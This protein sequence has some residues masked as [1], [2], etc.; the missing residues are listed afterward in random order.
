MR[1]CTV[2]LC[3]VSPVSLMPIHQATRVSAGGCGMTFE[4]YVAHC[5]TSSTRSMVKSWWRGSLAAAGNS[6]SED[7]RTGEHPQVLVDVS[8]GKREVPELV[9]GTS[10]W[11]T[12]KA[13]C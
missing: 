1:I 2:V 3:S 13:P 11:S 8:A 7:G 6:E 10:G 12:A 5:L 9:S 4:A